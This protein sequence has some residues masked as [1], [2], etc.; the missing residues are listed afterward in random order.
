MGKL[1][2]EIYEFMDFHDIVNLYFYRLGTCS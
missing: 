1:F 2:L